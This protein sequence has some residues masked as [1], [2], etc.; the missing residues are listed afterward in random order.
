MN[1]KTKLLI[2]TNFIL[3]ILAMVTIF[4]GAIFVFVAGK[5]YSARGG[6]NTKGINVDADN[7]INIG[8]KGSAATGGI[9]IAISVLIL[10]MAIV[11]FSLKLN[12]SAKKIVTISFV[13][14]LIISVVM[15]VMAILDITHVWSI[16]PWLINFGC[17]INFG[18]VLL[19]FK[20]VT[21]T[22]PSKSEAM[23]QVE[24]LNE[25]G[26]LK[27]A[28]YQELKERVTR[29]LKTET[30]EIKLMDSNG[31]EVVLEEPIEEPSKE[32]KETK[33][34]E[35]VKEETTKE[36]VKK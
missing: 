14:T 35:E 31:Q 5:G 32:P 12:K 1:K 21:A 8:D 15:F 11:F 16:W 7:L 25:N 17:L 24:Y 18:M 22:K 13:T 28:E 10:V 23:K 6:V 20:T 26:F 9:L 36:E 4:L 2:I 27:K 29:I 30:K 19:A 34:V 33:K 3:W